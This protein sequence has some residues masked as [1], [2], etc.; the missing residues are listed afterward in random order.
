M[1]I[2]SLLKIVFWVLV[3]VFVF[4]GAQ[5][6]IPLIRD[7]F[8]GSI[9]FLLPF[10]VFCLLGLTLIFLTIKGKIKGI[11]KKFLLLTGISAS[12][13]FLSVF[14]HNAFYALGIIVSHITVLRYL[15]E[16]LSAGFFIIAIFA[17]PLG[18]LIG[19]IGTIVLFIKK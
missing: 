14:L 12:G 18:F 11:L 15:M 3:A 2:S 17:C 6:L 16:F 10:A 7:L 4:I 9:L 13:F 19:V 5:F 1:T 8:K